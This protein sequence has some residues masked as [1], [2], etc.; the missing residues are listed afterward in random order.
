VSQ[1]LRFFDES[2]RFKY[3]LS[4]VA[5]RIVPLKGWSPE[6][7]F[8]FYQSATPFPHEIDIIRENAHSWFKVTGELLEKVPPDSTLDWCVKWYG[9]G[10]HSQNPLDKFL[11]YWRS[12]ERVADEELISVQNGITASIMKLCSGFMSKRE[13]KDFTR[14]CTIPSRYKVRYVIQKYIEDIR[15]DEIKKLEDARDGIAH[16]DITERRFDFIVSLNFKIKRY[17]RDILMKKLKITI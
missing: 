11:D 3:Y 16:G 2:N 17:V 14:R 5:E 7:K 8:Q 15:E 12:I 4:L 1:I 10:I 9:F 6:L 13:L